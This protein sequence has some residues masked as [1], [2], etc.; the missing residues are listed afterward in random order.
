[1]VAL[2]I[3][4]T[5]QASDLASVMEKVRQGVEAVVE[6]GHRTVASSR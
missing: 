4:E 5:E 6:Q 2:H 3:T 1:M